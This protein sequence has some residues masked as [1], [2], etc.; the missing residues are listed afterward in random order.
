MSKLRVLDLFSGIGGFSL[1]LERT[2]GFETVAFCEIDPFCQR[3]LAKH[4]PEVPCYEDVC[5]LN[6]DTLARD[7]I[8]IDVICGG[9]PCQDVSHAGKRAGLE[10]ARSGLWS[11]YARIIGEL[12]PRFVL[13]ENVPGLLSLGM[14]TVLGDLSALGYDAVW[15]CVSAA[16]VGAPHRR[17]RVWIIAHTQHPNANNAGSHRKALDV[18]RGAQLQY[19]QECEPR[20][21]CAD[22]ADANVIGRDGSGSQSSR[23][24][25][26]ENSRADVAD[27]IG[28][29]LDIGELHFRVRGK[30]QREIGRQAAVVGGE[31]RGRENVLADAV[32]GRRPGQGQLIDASNPAPHGQGQTVEFVDGGIGSIWRF[33][34]DVGRVANGVPDRAHRLKA[35]GN[36]VVPQIPEL[37]GRAILAA[38]AA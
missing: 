30:A 15:D 7:G 22:V 29:G 37:I 3:V 21:L 1:G 14:G 18:Y 25:Q 12:R 20:P 34:P 4:W 5:T 6:A 38:K 31:T 11:E 36:A 33:E 16:S 13:V 2:G 32:S 17:D 23:R 8:G 35:L 9:F 19:Q 27:A 24:P 10:G 28:E 26:S